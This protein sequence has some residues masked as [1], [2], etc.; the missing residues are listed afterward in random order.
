MAYSPST[1]K[2][3]SAAETSQSL[4]TVL[5]LIT[6]DKKLPRLPTLLYQR[7]IEIASSSTSEV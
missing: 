2:H 6:Q 3:L 4:T 5:F 7:I 1:I